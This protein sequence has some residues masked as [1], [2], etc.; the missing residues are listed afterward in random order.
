MPNG[1]NHGEPRLREYLDL[2]V[3]LRARRCN[4]SPPS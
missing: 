2:H 1:R 3:K 4:D